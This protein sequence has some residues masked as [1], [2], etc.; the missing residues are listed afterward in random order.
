MR[1]V[2]AKSLQ[3]VLES[4]DRVVDGGADAGRLGDEL[5]A[6]ARLLDAE[7][8]LRRTLTDPSTE[9][10]AQEGLARSIL[11]EKVGVAALEVVGAAV[12]GRWSSSRDMVDGLERAGVTAHVAGAE[13]HGQ[14]DDVEDELFRFGRFV[15]GDP[16]LRGVISDRTVPVDAKQQLVDTL[17]AGKSTAPAYALSRQ[18]V[19]ARADSFERTLEVFGDLAAARRERLLATVR[20]AYALAEGEKQRLAVA[21]G[22]QYG[23]EVHVNVIVDESVV[24]GLSVEIGDDIIDGTVSARLEDARRRIAG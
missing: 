13:R 4:V 14:L 21:L 8:A 22:R 17:L 23:R 10:D 24:G 12:Q 1:G 18:A 19:V 16:E 3:R 20:S 7:P 11:G 5:F 9:T 6:V 2:S 15:A